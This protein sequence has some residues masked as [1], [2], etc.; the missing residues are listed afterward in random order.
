MKMLSCLKDKSFEL[1]EDGFWKDLAGLFVVI[2]PVVMCIDC[3]DLDKKMA[4]MIWKWVGT[5]WGRTLIFRMDRCSVRQLRST[6][7]LQHGHSASSSS[8]C[9]VLAF[10]LWGRSLLV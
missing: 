7:W 5:L 9:R 4:E 6:L 3:H 8:L 1:Q 2:S 10:R